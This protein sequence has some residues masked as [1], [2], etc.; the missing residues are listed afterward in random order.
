MIAEGIETAAELD[1][2]IDLG[3]SYG[4]GFYL[5]RPGSLEE[6]ALL[7]RA[8]DLRGALRTIQP[9]A[10]LPGP[11]RR[12]SSGAIPSAPRAR[13]GPRELIR[14]TGQGGTVSHQRGS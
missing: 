3:I 8:G 1:V 9:S 6:L 7:L 11:G 2:L 5:G 4:Q 12:V 13:P 14:W 10:R